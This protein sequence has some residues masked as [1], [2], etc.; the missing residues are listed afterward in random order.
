MRRTEFDLNL[1]TVLDALIAERNVTRAGKQLSR[2]Q[3]AVSNALRRL[4]EILRDDLLVRGPN[5]LVLTPRAQALREPLHE[6]ISLIDESILREASFDPTL[7]NG[8]YR[9]S[10]PDRLTLAVVPPLMER[11]TKIAPGMDFHVVTADGRQAL[12]LLEHD[13]VDIAL[14][15]FDDK[16][17]F[18][19]QNSWRTR[20]SIASVA[21]AILS[22][23][24]K[25]R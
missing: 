5:G 6:I 22:R 19:T 24:P 3:P 14:G 17:E 21:E 7:A 2:S 13:Q 9:I 4:R 18:S 25:R 1:L 16:P 15:W 11:L 10:M 8:V 12:H 20:S 23:E